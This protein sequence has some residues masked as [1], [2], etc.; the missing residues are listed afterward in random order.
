MKIKTNILR[1]IV[2]GIAI[3][4][5]EGCSPPSDKTLE[6]R[7]IEYRESYFAL[8][9]MAKQD[10]NI[11]W[12]YMLSTTPENALTS[13]RSY[14]YRKRMVNL[15]ISS[16]YHDNK[17]DTIVM[18]VQRG[19]MSSTLKGYVYSE[20]ELSPL[21]NSLDD[22]PHNYMPYVNQYKKINDKVYIFKVYVN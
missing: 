14:E 5:S 12:I 21:H 16:L 3:L 19:Y 1:L 4:A 8:I 22:L 15:G 11:D 2:I 13:E 7:F 10:D 18:I 17:S 9:N 6:D 20:K